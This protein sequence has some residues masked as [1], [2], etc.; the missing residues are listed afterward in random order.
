MT[1]KLIFVTSNA[2]LHADVKDKKSGLLGNDYKKIL[3]NDVVDVVSFYADG[4][5][6]GVEI[7][8]Y[9]IKQSGTSTGVII[10]CDRDIKRKICHLEEFCFVFENL[11]YWNGQNPSN[12]FRRVSA[13][14]LKNYSYIVSRSTMIKYLKCLILPIHNFDAAEIREIR[15]LCGNSANTDRFPA[16]M[17]QRFEQLWRRQMPKRVK[18]GPKSYL[19]D[20][21]GRHFEFAH[22][23]HA[24]AE[25]GDPHEPLCTLKKN[26]RFGIRLEPQQHFNVSRDNQSIKGEGFVYCHGGTLAAPRD[27]HLNVF[28]GG[29]LT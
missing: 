25:T 22:E 5:Y 14:A 15:Q 18:S 17:E 19:V 4:N 9:A 23:H 24:Q 16:E 11:D 26:L 12:Y 8:R 20:D 29:Y 6:D 10:I 21:A 2:E 28:P 1:T 7:E 27:K 13:K 3:N